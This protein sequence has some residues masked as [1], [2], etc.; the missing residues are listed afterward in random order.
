MAG[1][2]QYKD[3]EIL[4]VLKA[5]LRG[6]SLRWIVTMF[7]SRFGRSLSDNQVRYIKNKYGRDP[8]FGTPVAN[9]HNF[10]ISTGGN[11]WPESDGVLD[12]DFDEF[13]R[14]DAHVPQ[15]N[16]RVSSFSRTTPSTPHSSAP[17][18]GAGAGAGTVPSPPPRPPKNC[19]GPLHR[20]GDEIRHAVAAGQK[21]AH[22][23]GDEDEDENDV[24]RLTGSLDLHMDQ[25]H[26]YLGLPHSADFL[27][28]GYGSTPTWEHELTT[29]AVEAI[30]DGNLPFWEGPTDSEPYFLGW[31]DEEEDGMDCLDGAETSIQQQQHDGHHNQLISR[32]SHILWMEQHNLSHGSQC[33][34]WDDALLAP[35]TLIEGFEHYAAAESSNAADMMYQQLAATGHT[36]NQQ[37]I[38]QLAA[39]DNAFQLQGPSS[40][41]NG[42][43]QVIQTSDNSIMKPGLVHYDGGLGLQAYVEE[44]KNEPLDPLPNAPFPFSFPFLDCH[45]PFVHD[46]AWQ[47][48]M[49]GGANDNAVIST[50]A[51]SN[52]GLNPW[53]YSECWPSVDA[54]SLSLVGDQQAAGLG[55]DDVTA[56]YE[57]SNYLG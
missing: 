1:S 22:D 37:A 33:P 21:R 57:A 12:I 44:D 34:G 32:D 15:P 4:F 6:L 8:R 41:G 50:T 16:L 19:P 42:T 43:H 38:L 20:D 51:I 46:D 40:R 39:Q 24:D 11:E 26:H 13:E 27:A 25:L 47:T 35:D 52:D 9:T 2:Q 31:G 45:A 49:S 29:T 55:D 18:A 17:S 36:S 28:N 56:S 54:A 48:D 10:G 7:E 30:E 23:D 14:Q 5:I 3:V 53:S